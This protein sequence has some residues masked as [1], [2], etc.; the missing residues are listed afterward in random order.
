MAVGEYL[1]PVIT[2]L[3]MDI[4]DF[5]A[6]VAEAKAMM[7][8]LAG[9]ATV[10][11]DA[12]LNKASV[13]AAM[14]QAA[15][16]TNSFNGATVHI[17]TDVNM[18]S[19]LASLASIKAAISSLNADV[20]VGAAGAAAA[21]A[22]GFRLFGWLN[23]NTLHWIIAGGAEILAVTVPAFI[24]L[25]SAVAVAAEGATDAYFHFT[26][27]YTATEA[28]SNVF[29]QTMGTVL[30]MGDALQ[31]AQTAA[32]P[33]VYGILGSAIITVKEH[34]G[35]LATTGL[36]VVQM[37]QT[38]AA[39][40][41]VDFGPG[42]AL[43]GETTKLLAN[44]TSDLRGIGQL[45]G[46][47]GHALLAF[48]SQM[49]GLAEVLLA[50]LVGLTKF[51][52][53]AIELGSKLHIGSV[54]VITLA[55][56]FEEFNRWGG[57][58]AT[59]L[60][61][62]GLASAS[63]TGGPFSLTRFASVVQG[64][65]SIL[66]LAIA[67]LAKFA[68]VIGLDGI[69]SGLT[70][71]SEGLAGVIEKI[72]PFQATL[73]VAAAVGLGI[74][75]DKLLTARTA[76]QQFTDSLQ[77]LVLKASNLNAF[78]VIAGNIEQLNQRLAQTAPLLNQTGGTVE[79]RLTGPIMVA[80]GAIGQLHQGLTQQETDL[81]NVSAGAAYL[82]QTYHTNLVTAMGLAD[83]ANVKLASGITG[84]SQAAMIARVQIAS[85][86]QGYE[87]MGA[88]LTAV[89]SDIEALA[90][91]SGLAGT[92]VSQL[93]SAWDEFMSNLTGGTSGLAGFVTA[94]SNIGT[95]AGH[96]SNN[97]ST[98]TTTMSLSTSQ[99]A[100]ALTS[101][102]VTG[103]SAWTNFN[104]VVGSTAP[105]LID[106]L[107]TAGAEG[108]LSGPQFTKAVL[109]MASS[110]V[111]LAANSQTAQVEVLGLIHQ[112][113]PSITTWGQLQ[114]ALKNSGASLSNLAPLIDG[115]TSKMGNMSKVAQALGT[116]TDTAL[117]SVLSNAKIMASGVGS[118][119]VAYEQALMNG[120]K[121]TAT[122][123]ANVISDLEKI[124][125]SFQQAAQIANAAIASIPTHVNTTVDITIIS[126]A[127]TG[128]APGGGI[129][130]TPTGHAAG[131]PAASPG[132]AWV[133]EAGPE[134]VRFRGG[135]TVLPNHVSRGF[136]GGAG[137]MPGSHWHLYID[138]REIS[139]VVAKQA[140][141]SQRRTGH[142]GMAKRTR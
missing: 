91:Q 65:L 4:G 7:K 82:A 61:K 69:G 124:G 142:N 107:R 86:V 114:T 62:L 56:A 131:T 25:G 133:G 12:D 81:R 44:M 35:D 52:T 99:F 14:G 66:P 43:G 89:G 113:L 119:M 29:H 17:G 15:A 118:A 90:I 74:F 23:A 3:S 51:V 1:P 141:Q 100:K 16:I 79:S 134:L 45:F 31:Q 123:R 138:G 60:T 34:F 126:Q 50:G 18:A 128:H 42:G 116:D 139:N 83:A 67:Q 94:L 8:G 76:T 101:F 93:N 26:A 95:V 73:I 137:D 121:N 98:S 58:A 135:E 38:F 109:D 47:L 63:L 84:S 106:W 68:Y 64:L 39:K 87:A 78:Q 48:G 129:L 102:N 30:G 88:P 136:A 55:M 85:L 41:A 53:E 104:Q 24:A 6:K 46:N 40:V 36:Q 2:R 132:W 5:A 49:P 19:L 111:P 33:S 108:A 130:P 77:Q 11:V 80:N 10:S 21:T 37:F 57:L 97:L 28:T 92:K 54:S 105:Q 140:I 72:T 13:A 22:A 70:G 96:T 75:I 117:E 32:D 110:L 9:D 71:M 127:V 112:V 122:L 120:S 125:Y 103:S 27:L 20:G 115:A 59:V